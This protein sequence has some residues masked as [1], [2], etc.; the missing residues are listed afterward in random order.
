MPAHASLLHH[1]SSNPNASNPTNHVEGAMEMEVTEAHGEE[2]E[3]SDR[4]FAI[5]I[6]ALKRSRIDPGRRK[7]DST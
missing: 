3:D 1:G 6:T 5:K 4:S 2:M 7:R